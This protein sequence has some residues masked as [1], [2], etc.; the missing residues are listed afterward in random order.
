MKRYAYHPSPTPHHPPPT[1]HHP[2]PI[3]NLVLLAALVMPLL[4]GCARPTPN[5]PVA[6][7]RPTPPTTPA[8]PPASPT[9]HVALAQPP[10]A[11]GEC[12]ARGSFPPLLHGLSY[13]V[14]AFLLG[15][16]VDRVLA[17]TTAAQFGWVRQ[18]I[19]WRDIEGEPGRFVWAPLDAAVAQ[20]R[21]NSLRIMLSVV[22]SP[23]WAG[24][25]GGLPDDRAAFAGFLQALAARYRG[26]VSA[27]QVWNEPNLAV[28][29]G[30]TPATPEAYLATLRAAYPAIKAGDPCA[31]VVSAALAATA[32]GDAAVA[33]NDL[34]FLDTLYQLDGSVFRQVADVV[35]IHPGGGPYHPEAWWPHEQPG[36]SARYFR[37]VER[38]RELMQ[39]YHDPRQAWI[40]EVGWSVAQAPGAPAPVSEQQQAEH[41][42]VTMY[43][44]RQ[45]YPWISAIF[46]WNL[47][48]GIAAAPGDEKATFGLLRP[49]WTPRPAFLT[50]QTYLNDEAQAVTASQPRFSGPAPFRPGWQARVTGKLRTPATFGSDGSVYVGSDA[51]WLYAFSPAGGL[52]WSYDAPGMVRSAPALGPDGTVFLLDSHGTLTA[53]NNVGRP[54][55]QQRLG[56]VGHGR[57]EVVGGGLY[58]AVDDALLR[59]DLAG[60]VV[61]RTVVGDGATQPAVGDPFTD[62]GIVVTTAAGAVIGLDASGGVRWRAQ[63]GASALSP[64]A[65]DPAG[66]V[67]VGDGNGVLY[68]LDASDG[69]VRWKQ[70]VVQR[71]VSPTLGPDTPLIAASPLVTP[72][73]AIYLAG[74]DGSVTALDRSGTVRWR[75]QSNS[76]ISATPA[77]LADG[78]IV[79]GLMDQRVLGIGPDGALRWQVK[80]RGAVRST[81]R[82]AP[83]GTLYISTIGGMVYALFARP[84]GGLGLR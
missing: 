5:P 37:H 17:L 60:N 79:V 21:G 43:H 50:L 75:Y 62:P 28:E 13:G 71:V 57:P 67:L 54:L 45:Y 33:T 7:Q 6:G 18:Q 69:A 2:S 66:V 47:N 51:G 23:A 82:S 32:T 61:W 12:L 40:T 31:L 14:N 78:T 76:D 10:G 48:F 41:L 55:W 8:P 19:H 42:L 65:L 52:R 9:A 35:G 58:V 46:V 1:T 22:R 4:A 3:L 16:D 70:S 73:G 74:R 72:D 25:D 63:L 77:S 15:P 56:E 34:A 11:P 81:P 80:L 26:Q 59:V 64:P 30:G 38:V 68:G 29:N 84:G 20:A 83:D 53:L 27:Y 24:R 39:R 44:T 36:E 49:D